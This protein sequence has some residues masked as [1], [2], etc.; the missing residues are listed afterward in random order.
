VNKKFLFDFKK[1]IKIFDFIV[2]YVIFTKNNKMEFGLFYRNN[3]K[4][5]ILKKWFASLT[6]AYHFF[7]LNKR[8]DQKQFD[9]IFVVIPIIKKESNKKN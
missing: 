8:I 4:E 5:C 1:F 3:L 2:F 6:D 9:E 7:L